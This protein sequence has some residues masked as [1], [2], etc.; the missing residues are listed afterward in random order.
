MTITEKPLSSAER[1]ICIA[2]I[3]GR[4]KEMQ[5]LGIS[6][7][8]QADHDGT[9]SLIIPIPGDESRIVIGEEERARVA[10]RH[11]LA[12]LSM[13]KTISILC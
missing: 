8:A 2:Q 10:L 11:L 6:F 7:T 3:H 13:A 4:T 1:R 12:D 9:N 5:L